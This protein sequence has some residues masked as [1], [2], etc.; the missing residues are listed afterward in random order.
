MPG[1]VTNDWAAQK[2]VI[3]RTKPGRLYDFNTPLQLRHGE[4]DF[5]LLAETDGGVEELKIHY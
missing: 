1:L 5:V 2:I 3:V 4:Y